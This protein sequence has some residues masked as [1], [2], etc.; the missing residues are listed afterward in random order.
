MQTIWVPNKILTSIQMPF[1]NQIV[2]QP[3]TFWPFKYQ[4]TAN[5]LIPD[6]QLPEPFYLTRH[7]LVNGKSDTLAQNI[8]RTFYFLR[9][10]NKIVYLDKSD[11]LHWVIRMVA[12]E[13]LR[14]VRKKA[15][16][17]NWYSW[18]RLVSPQPSAKFFYK[19]F[20]FIF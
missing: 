19:N 5:I 13:N 6:T 10:K 14:R 8:G 16:V 11:S 4:T 9:T 3:D 17:E 1:D 20:Y 2:C 12:P 7:H 18:F 15:N